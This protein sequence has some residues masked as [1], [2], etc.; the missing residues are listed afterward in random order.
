[1]SARGFSLIELV[2]VMVIAAILAAVAIPRFTDSESKATWY[3]EQALAAVRFAQRQAVAQ[4][5]NIYVCVNSSSVLNIDY[6]PACAVANAQVC[7]S[8]AAV[9]QIPQKFCGPTG[10]NNSSTTTPFSFDALGQPSPIGGVTVTVSG[11]SINVTGQT[12]YVF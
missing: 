2:V 7:Q 8:S 6:D 11:R 10:A 9:I 5:R 4:R 3:H 1:M 12:G